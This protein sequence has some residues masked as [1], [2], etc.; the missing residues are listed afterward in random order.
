MSDATVISPTILDAILNKS[1][2]KPCFKPVL[3]YFYKVLSTRLK[4]GGSNKHWMWLSRNQVQS[5]WLAIYIYGIISSTNARISLFNNSLGLIYQSLVFQV[6][7][8][9]KNGEIK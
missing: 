2:W 6:N 9:S 7:N 8:L 5:K 1:M 4:Y 3:F